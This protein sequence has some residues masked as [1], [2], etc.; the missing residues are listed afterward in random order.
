M[1]GLV[2]EAIVLVAS[3]LVLVLLRLGRVRAAFALWL[4]AASLLPGRVSRAS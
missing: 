3:A 4:A 1:C 2:G